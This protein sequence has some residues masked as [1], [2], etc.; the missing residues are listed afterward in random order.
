MVLSSHPYFIV[1]FFSLRELNLIYSIIIAR[2]ITPNEDLHA[3]SNMH[4]Q[5]FPLGVFIS[6]LAHFILLTTNQTF[7]MG[8]LTIIINSTH[9]HKPNA[10]SFFPSPPIFPLSPIS[11]FSH[12][13]LHPL[14]HLSS[15]F[16]YFSLPPPQKS[17]IT[18]ICI[19]SFKYN[20]ECKLVLSYAAGAVNPPLKYTFSLVYI[21]C[22]N[23]T[24]FPVFHH[25]TSKII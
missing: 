9:A 15:K 6:L 24:F 13:Y 2:L 14:Y 10:T 19:Y 4:L 17:R 8:C 5:D 18:N 12:W 11:L 22:K 21:S 20:T 25:H 16:S 1:L 3:C 7:P 23:L